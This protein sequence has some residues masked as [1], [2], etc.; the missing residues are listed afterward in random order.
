MAKN[1]RNNKR[2]TKR[3]TTKGKVI[4]LVFLLWTVLGGIFLSKVLGPTV[5]LYIL[6][7]NHVYT[8]KYGNPSNWEAKDE[9]Y[10]EYT[11]RVNELI[12]TSGVLSG[13]YSMN[14]GLKVLS[15][16]G[17]SVP[18]FLIIFLIGEGISEAT[19]KRQKSSRLRGVR[20]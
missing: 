7:D 13:Y 12:N 11:D 5:E 4:I 14:G 18:Y 6:Q 9:A 16:L 8:E 20:A 19:E 15:I 3:V 17:A 1:K 10:T 2:G